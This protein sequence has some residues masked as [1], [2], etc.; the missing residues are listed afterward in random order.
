ML[1]SVLWYRI[2]ICLDMNIVMFRIKFIGI[3]CLMFV[4]NFLGKVCWGF[5]NFIMVFLLMCIICI[6]NF[7]YF[8]ENNVGIMYYYKC[9]FLYYCMILWRFIYNYN[10][11]ICYYYGF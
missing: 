5:E 11:Y 10:I 8:V 7:I 3:V 9:L 4:W 1:F 6:G 2:L